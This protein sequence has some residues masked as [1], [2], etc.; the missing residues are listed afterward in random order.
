VHVPAGA[1]ALRLGDAAIWPLDPTPR[2][3]LQ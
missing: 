1:D 3:A 2:S